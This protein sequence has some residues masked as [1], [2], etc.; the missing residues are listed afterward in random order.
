MTLPT[1]E[2]LRELSRDDLIARVLRQAE[3]LERR[4]A[5]S[6]RLKRPPPTSRN[7]SQPPS[8]DQKP[9]APAL[10]KRYRKHR[11]HLLVSQSGHD[12][13]VPHHT[14]AAERALRPSVIHRKVTGG[15][16]SA[17]GA[18]AYAALVS[19][20]DTAQLRG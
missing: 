4:E 14:N 7:S 11:A 16:R 19:V 1:V 3:R 9:A 18:H 2:R 20:I 12:P 10:V 6:E 15:F 8:R 13:A 17:W 5:E